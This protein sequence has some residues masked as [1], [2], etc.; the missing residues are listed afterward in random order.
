V[1]VAWGVC[2]GIGYGLAIVSWRVPTG[3]AFECVNFFLPLAVCGRLMDRWPL[4]IPGPVKV[5]D[6]LQGSVGVLVLT[7]SF[8]IMVRNLKSHELR[9]G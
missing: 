3:K 5:F 8:I 6:V 4:G 7:I 1:L 2:G 9:H